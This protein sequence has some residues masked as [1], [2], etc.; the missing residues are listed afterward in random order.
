MATAHE[1]RT[2]AAA[3]K[4][5]SVQRKIYGVYMRSV[6]ETKVVLLITEIGKNIKANLE[7]KISA[8]IAGKC[9]ADGYVKPNSIKIIGYSSGSLFGEYVDFHVVYECMVCLPV[10][11]MLIKCTCKTVTKAGIHAQ[12]IDDEQNVPVTVFVARDHHYLD[13][14]FDSI[15]PNELITVRVIGTRFE[16]HDPYICVIAKL[17]DIQESAA[18]HMIVKKNPHISIIGGIVEGM[19][20]VEEISSDDEAD[21]E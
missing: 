18:K 14:R 12:V 7:T 19:D 8:K 4:D 5:A 9:M 1:T 15:Q 17:T 6:L 13:K 3:R 20:G 16:L 2:L 11:G 10:D 21:H